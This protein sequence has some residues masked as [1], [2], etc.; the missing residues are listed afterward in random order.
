MAVDSDQTVRH[1]TEPLVQTHVYFFDR[2]MSAQTLPI[3]VDCQ[4]GLQANAPANNQAPAK[5]AWGKTAYT[6]RIVQAICT[7]K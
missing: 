3:W 4:N 2:R 6:D 1:P 5:L 7:E